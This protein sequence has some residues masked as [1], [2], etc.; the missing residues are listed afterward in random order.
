M[1]SRY[2][3]QFGNEGSPLSGGSAEAPRTA[4]PSAGGSGLAGELTAEESAD[5][6]LAVATAERSVGRRKLMGPVAGSEGG[7]SEDTS[8]ETDQADSIAA[9]DEY[10][11]VPL[12]GAAT[13]VRPLR[14]GG[15][16]GHG[17]FHS[18]QAMAL[19]E[20]GATRHDG[21][22]YNPAL[23][24]S[25]SHPSDG[26][27]SH[28]LEDVY[29]DAD[30]LNALASPVG[31]GPG[32]AR[33]QQAAATSSLRFRTP[34]PG[35]EDASSIAA[36][37]THLSATHDASLVSDGSA[38]SD[39]GSDA[40]EEVLQR[41]PRRDLA[42]AAVAPAARRT[43]DEDARSGPEREERKGRNSLTEE[44]RRLE[45]QMK[46]EDDQ[47]DPS[48]PKTLQEA[49]RLAK[50]RAKLRGTGEGGSISAPKEA[51][52][53]DM[54]AGSKGRPKRDPRRAGHDSIVGGADSAVAAD[55]EESLQHEST[56]TSLREKRQGQVSPRA[57]QRASAGID[58]LQ[59]AVDATLQELS[60]T[61][62][63]GSDALTVSPQQVRTQVTPRQSSLS[64][65]KGPPE[66]DATSKDP[67]SPK[68]LKPIGRI[69]V[70]GK[71]APWPDAF[72]SL[73][74]V[75]QR[76]SAAWDRAKLYAVSAN[77]L[78]NM[79]TNLSHWIDAKRR[80]AT[81]SGEIRFLYGSIKRR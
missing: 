50:E 67:F 11:D 22:R 49:R 43:L 47:R 54:V 15:A 45:A 38:S 53:L 18:Q 61:S 70:Y 35:E 44:E 24:N 12:D 55:D 80:P 20:V 48:R 10:S 58:E 62:T 79:E 29:T 76:R 21:S 13:D 40:H 66:E 37:T 1:W 7:Q 2:H 63:A 60:F 41:P 71:T 81:R 64:H 59:G 16:D 69:E 17:G 72:D 39:Y 9:T 57:A 4:Q 5:T 31:E 77:T 27:A 73:R 65:F 25:G 6:A 42:Q 8:Y 56:Q 26:D 52:L 75:E 51:L 23:P 36:A 3:H 33:S 14:S 34:E 19:A 74:I 46:L 30:S 32:F 28:S 68:T 78:L